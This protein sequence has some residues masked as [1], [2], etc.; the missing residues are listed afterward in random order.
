MRIHELRLRNFISHKE[1][2]I[3]FPSGLTAIIG[4]NGAGKTSILDAISY[5]L[6][7]EHGRGRDEN[8]I[9]RRART[10][11][12]KLI[13]SSGGRRY[14]VTWR[15]ERKKRA[16]A[17][18]R[19]LE[20]GAFIFRD[21][22][23]RT[24]IPEIGKRLGM[25]KEIFLNASYVRQGEIARLLEARPADRKE[26]IS[27]LLGVEAL[28]KIW[29]EL[30]TPIRALE[31]KKKALAEEAEKRRELEEKLGEIRSQ[32]EGLSK[33][34]KMLKTEIEHLERELREIKEKIEREEEKRKRYEELTEVSA[35][36]EKEIAEKRRKLEEERR[37]LGLVEEAE[38]KIRELGDVKDRSDKLSKEVRE[39]ERR[40]AELDAQESGRKLIE[41]NLEK[42]EGEIRSLRSEILDYAERL[43]RASGQEVGE[44]NFAKV[45]KLAE[46]KYL[47][48]EKQLRQKLREIDQ[49]TGELK[50]REKSLL[51]DIEELEL[52]GDVCPLCKRP[53]SREHK[54]KVLSQLKSELESI[55]GKLRSLEEDKEEAEARLEEVSETIRELSGIDADEFLSKVEKLKNLEKE[56]SELEVELGKIE[57]ASRGEIEKALKDKL[58]ELEE[59]KEK[60]AEYE[61][62]KGLIEKLG[63]SQT[64][65]PRIHR[66]SAELE[67]LEKE[68]D[69]VDAEL[70]K[71][72]YD[73]EAYEEMTKELE[74]IYDK[75]SKAKSRYAEVAQR[76][77]SLEGER[78]RIEEELGK[79]REA[80]EKLKILDEY[81]RSLKAIR[82]C[83]GKDG[84]QKYIRANARKSIEHYARRFLQFFNLAYSDLRLDEDYNIYVYGPFGEQ[85]IDSLSGGEKTAIALCLRLGIAAALTGDRM[86]CILMDE[87]T[88]HLDPERRRELIRLLT[89]F[90]SDRGLIPQAIIV[91]HD[92]E[93]EQ[94]AD[95]VYHIKISEGYS[96]V[97]KAEQ[98]IQ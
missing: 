10:A 51:R 86:E 30:K 83:F 6:F 76:I 52:G 25:S 22:G 35:K 23:E 18:L 14:E 94:A 91:T 26:I 38:R 2:V 42:I 82:E 49:K 15:L 61:R 29:S 12:I 72:G 31:E 80:E 79:A 56:R 34:E 93:I 27:K 77:K 75:I 5:A 58:R 87:P 55:E 92:E 47:E 54:E 70:E 97:E 67:D 90:R 46:T 89:N 63:S 16:T 24:A 64:I 65:L 69:R 41:K 32:A 68:R 78:E 43:Q 96:K 7:K 17:A 40:L 19:D 8:L 33:E 74:E 37:D 13:F 36:L 28:E 95:Q 84:V 85:S 62:E 81:V 1:T 45:L 98:P 21:V 9:N 60:A 71:L 11:E 44:E 48:L 39:L 73:R 53:M 59:L 88:T 3:E 66:L 57:E 4:R 50:G 20:T